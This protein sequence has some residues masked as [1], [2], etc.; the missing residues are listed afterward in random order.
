MTYRFSARRSCS[1][2]LKIAHSNSGPP[3]R[4]DRGRPTPVKT[5]S[6]PGPFEALRAHLVDEAGW[7][8]DALAEH[9]F[10]IHGIRTNCSAM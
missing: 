10:H 4:N 5:K 1:S 2:F 8:N 7:M 9:Q 3:E 6:A